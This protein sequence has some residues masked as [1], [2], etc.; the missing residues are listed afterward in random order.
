MFVTE[1]QL[2]S[3][4]P[5]L[6][7]AMLMD[8]LQADVTVHRDPWGIPHIQAENE[9]DLFVAQGFVTAQDRLWHMA[10]DRHR[11]LGRW[12]EWVGESGVDQDRLM[13]A[14]GMGRTAKLDYEACSQVARAMVDAY[15]TGV[16]AFIQSTD[17]FP[18]EYTLLE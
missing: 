6:T 8:A 1:D 4:L 11:A 12:A 3:A 10:Y 16:N 18:I 13:R 5:D 9:N 14:A 15:T 17:S 2:K 7:S